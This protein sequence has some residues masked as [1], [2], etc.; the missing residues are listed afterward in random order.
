LAEIARDAQVALARLELSKRVTTRIRAALAHLSAIN[1]T[2]PEGIEI[3]L[4]LKRADEAT[5]TRELSDLFVALGDAA[6]SKSRGVVF[7]IDEVQFADEIEFR[8]VI[9]A[10][11]RATQRSLPITM[12]AAG[13]PQIPRLTG[14]ARS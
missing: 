2:G 13:L 8:A 6:R 9:S 14:E 3:A 10:L 4:D 11:H 1:I 5:L 7:L 12:A